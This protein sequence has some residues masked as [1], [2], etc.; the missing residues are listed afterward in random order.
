MGR[1]SAWNVRCG[2][3]HSVPT[4]HEERMLPRSGGRQRFADFT[5]ADYPLI[6]TALA[7]YVPKLRMTH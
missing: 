6:G 2:V 3:G 5:P 1:P 4:F 7:D